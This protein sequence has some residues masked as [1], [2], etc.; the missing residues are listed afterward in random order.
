MRE[1]LTNEQFYE[2]CDRIDAL[3]RLALSAT[4]DDRARWQ[5]VAQAHGATVTR[6]IDIASTRKLEQIDELSE[7]GRLAWLAHAL[8]E[9]AGAYYGFGR[10]APWQ[11]HGYD[12]CSPGGLANA[13][14]RMFRGDESDGAAEPEVS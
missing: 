14:A 8:H 9:F 13:L 7:S 12:V 3:V 1:A 4:H 2:T 5:Q 6:P 10:D 11:V